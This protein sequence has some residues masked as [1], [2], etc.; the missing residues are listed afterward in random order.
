MGRL[1]DGRL[2]SIPGT[3]PGEQVTARLNGGNRHVTAAQLLQVVHPSPERVAPPCQHAAMCGGC[4]LQHWATQPYL[5]WKTERLREA[6]VRAGF[7]DPPVVSTVAISPDTRRRVDL[8]YAPS[9]G[10]TALGFHGSRDRHVIDI[11]DCTILHEDLRRLI[12]PL[13]HLLSGL[14][15]CRQ[16]G[17]V[18]INLLDS[19]PDILLGLAGSPTSKDRDRLLSFARAV[20][21]CRIH[22]AYGSGEPELLAMLAAPTVTFGDIRVSP[23]PGSF[24]QASR[25][26][27]RHLVKAALNALPSPLP[28]R[29][30][31]LDLYAGCGTFTL[32]LAAHGVVDAFEGDVRAVAALRQA[33]H[34][35]LPG[36]VAA[37]HRD[38]L[39]RP[40]AGQELRGYAVAVI[41]PPWAGAGGQ[42]AAL[43][44]ST[45]PRI[46]YV[47]C[48]PA[49]LS[50]DARIL[51][52]AG[53][54]VTRATPVDQFVWSAHLESVVV[55]AKRGSPRQT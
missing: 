21:A 12:T 10:G 23:P 18:H 40:L 7:I 53:F 38:L 22:Y 35:A 8:A 11:Q 9:A 5:A 26:G 47:S 48:N 34:H 6:L 17:S 28:K 30:R 49:S 45:V 1:A 39:R 2:V 36:R 27:E 44:A 37:H 19:G 33:A 32:P 13:R 3:L 31:F 24:L 16:P 46:I 52:D 51:R 50:N 54:D 29:A 20:G 55:F 14:S 43:A 41:D 42:I 25:D 15:A 4:T